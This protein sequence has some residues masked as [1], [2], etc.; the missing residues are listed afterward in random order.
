MKSSE[1]CYNYNDEKM[2]K[3]ESNA[4][5]GSKVE[6]DDEPDEWFVGLS[7]EWEESRTNAD[8]ASQG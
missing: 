8:A 4:A 7:S 5:S 3:S 1:G 2:T 6:D